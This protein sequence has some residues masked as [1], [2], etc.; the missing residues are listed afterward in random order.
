VSLSDCVGSLCQIDFDAGQVCAL[1]ET[2]WVSGT[3]CMGSTLSEKP[4][5]DPDE[6]SKGHVSL[7]SQDDFGVFVTDGCL[8]TLCVS[9]SCGHG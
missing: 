9:N 7:E 3:D 8:E 6:S 4:P 2:L 1:T 5:G